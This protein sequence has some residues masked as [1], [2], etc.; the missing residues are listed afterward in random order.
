MVIS[1][2]DTFSPKQFEEARK[3]CGLA[4]KGEPKELKYSVE[5]VNGLDDVQLE[6]SMCELTRDNDR[7][8]IEIAVALRGFKGERDQ[9]L[10]LKGGD[11][12]LIESKIKGSSWMFGSIGLRKGWFPANMVR[13]EEHFI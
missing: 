3:S 11:K 12:I 4:S 13:I 9:D 2:L 5:Y 10:D 6:G 8:K 7:K 1:E